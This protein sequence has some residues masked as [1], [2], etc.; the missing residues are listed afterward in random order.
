MTRAELLESL[1]IALDGIRSRKT[2][3]FL[4]VLGVVIGVTSV[5]AVAAIIEGLNRNIMQRV[6][7]LGSKTFFVTRIPLA[8]FGRLPEEIRLRKH[9][10]FDDARVI[11][12]SCP[13]VEYASAFATRALFFGDPNDIR[14][15][16]EKVDNTIL[17]GVDPNY[18]NAIPIFEV[19]QGRFISAYDQ[20]HTRYVAAIGQGIANTLFPNADPIGRTV[21]L[22]GLPFEVIGVFEKDSGMFGGPGVDMFVCIPYSTFHKLYPEIREHFIAISV[23]DPR[24]LSGAEDEVVTALRR[25]RRVPH[26]APND[27]EITMPDFLTNL[28]NQLT[29]ALVILTGVIS[30]IALLVGGIGVMNIMLVSVTERTAEIGVRKAVGARRSDIRAQFLI[31]AVTLTSIGGVAGI[32]IGA[33]ISWTVQALLPALPTYVSPFWAVMGLLMAAGVGLFFGYYPARRAANLDP[34]VCLRYE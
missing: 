5:I 2:R 7:A 3:S 16:S 28:W 10:T 15:G 17:R 32:L 31:E 11:R 25:L 19:V 4:T 12:E 23:R 6:Q 22:N 14:Y 8:R 18:A 1:S 24:E 33:A 20:D 34:I 27:F 13:T 26:D 30:S 21:R 29:G 9:F